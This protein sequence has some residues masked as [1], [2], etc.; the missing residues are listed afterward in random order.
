V[1][2]LGLEMALL[3]PR[4][5]IRTVLKGT[6]QLPYALSNMTIL[7]SEVIGLVA[8]K[9]LQR[10]AREL[11][12]YEPAVLARID[13]LFD[14]IIT[15]EIGH[16]M[17]LQSTMDAARLAATRRMVPLVARAFL[18]DIP[19]TSMVL[20]REDLL[21]SIGEAARMGHVGFDDG[22]VHPLEVRAGRRLGCDERIASLQLV[23]AAAS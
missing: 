20:G 16:V 9:A 1:R 12:G 6:L 19:V 21:E 13:A 2:A 10:M 14:Q 8:F 11:F 22:R 4:A 23:E 18:R 7:A 5:V 15:D 17:F 3:P